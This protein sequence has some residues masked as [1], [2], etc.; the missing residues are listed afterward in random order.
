VLLEKIA[1]KG[2]FIGKVAG[3]LLMAWGIWLLI[4]SS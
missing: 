2:L 3:V 1:P 4:G